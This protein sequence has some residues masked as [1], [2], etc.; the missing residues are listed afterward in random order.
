MAYV[1]D[2]CNWF[3]YFDIPRLVG[4]WADLPVPETFLNII[5][6]GRIGILKSSLRLLICQ[7]ILQRT[8]TLPWM[9]YDTFWPNMRRTSWWLKKKNK[10]LWFHK[11]KKNTKQKLPSH[12]FF[13]RHLFCSVKN[14]NN[15]WKRFC[16]A[17][18]YRRLQD[19]ILRSAISGTTK[20]QKQASKSSVYC[21]PKIARF[22]SQWV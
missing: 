1:F 16:I 17:R 22:R 8:C 18:A 19:E 11:K 15:L 13:S 21:S 14:R 2:C 20:F 4:Q 12:P 6:Y 3:K 5:I 9:V 7:A 10:K